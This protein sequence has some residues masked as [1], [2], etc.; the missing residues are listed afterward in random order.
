MMKS[1]SLICSLCVNVCLQMVHEEG[2]MFGVEQAGYFKAVDT[3]SPL[4]VNPGRVLIADSWF[5]SVAC[6]LALFER[7]IFAVMNVKTAHRGYPKDEL[8]AEVGE[9][10][11]NTADAKKLRAEKRGKQAAFRQE[12]TVAGG[13]TVTVTAAGHNKKLPLLLVGT[14]SNM[15]PGNEHKKVWQAP[16]PDG[17]LQ[18]HS[19]VTKQPKMHALYRENMNVVDVHNKLRQGVVSMADVWQTSSWIERHFAEGLGLW[20]ENVYKALC[21]FQKGRWAGV[22]HNHFRMRLAHAFMTLGKVPYPSDPGAA[23][24]G[25]TPSPRG[26][27][28]FASPPNTFTCPPPDPTEAEY[29]HHQ[30]LFFSS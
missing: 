24:N 26:H 12:F 2:G 1:C 15:L 20:E 21:Y 18:W 3:P 7:T 22:S 6:A 23:A 4:V 9:V 13:R 25:T 8:L 16:L 10:K 5:G 11:G 30:H 14:H 29:V 28:S 19:R 27:P 17:T